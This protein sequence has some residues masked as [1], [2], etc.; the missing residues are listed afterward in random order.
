V[1]QGMRARPNAPR[2]RG[3]AH[4]GRKL[5]AQTGTTGVPTSARLGDGEAAGG[6]VHRISPVPGASCGSAAPMDPETTASATVGQAPRAPANSTRRFHTAVLASGPSTHAGTAAV[7]E[8]AWSG[9]AESPRPRTRARKLPPSSRFLHNMI[10]RSE[11]GWVR[12]ANA[13]PIWQGHRSRGGR[14]RDLGALPGAHGSA[15]PRAPH[16]S[17]RPDDR[18]SPAPRR[19]LTSPRVRGSPTPDRRAGLATSQVAKR[20]TASHA[21]ERCTPSQRV[22]AGP[23]VRV[24][25]P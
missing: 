6:N 23:G 19:E 7:P 15:W 2:R 16:R 13:V 22:G 5:R 8:D 1:R 25:R 10:A 17:P 24:S 20:R 3:T 21:R 9:T 18:R 14:L 4:P 11:R 12:T